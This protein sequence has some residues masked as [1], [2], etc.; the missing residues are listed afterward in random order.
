[1]TSRV[2][3]ITVI[4][5]QLIACTP[6]A[7]RTPDDTIVLVIE[8][9]MTT[10]DPR[11]AISSHD[12]K[13]T[14]LVGA[15]L[16]AVD[17]PDVEPRLDLASKVDMIDPLTFDFTIR[18]DAKFSDG[19]P[20]TAEDVAWTY[21]SVLDP[22]STSLHHKGFVE[23]YQS[24]V[25]RSPS[26]VRFSLK[27]PL[28]TLTSDLDFAI[29]SKGKRLGAGPYKLRELN[30]LHVLLDVNPHYYGPK[31]KTPHVEI[32]F[33]RDAS[34]RLLMLVGGS[35]DL[36]QNSIRLDLIDEVK[37]RPRIAIEAAPSVILTYLM[38]NNADPVLKDL[39]VRQAIALAIDRQAIVDAKFGGRAKLASGLL[40]AFH[41]AFAKE[42]PTWTRDLPRARQLLDEAGLRDPDGDGPRPR[43]SLVYKTSSDAFRVTLAR[44]IA[45]QLAEVGIDVEVRSF[46]F[47][48]FFA[49]VK[50]GSY[51]LASMQSAEL[52][53][54]DY[55]YFYFHSSRI[56]DAKNPDGGNRWRYRN[57]TL[58]RLTE[59]GRREM[60]REKRKLI[61]AEA[62][63]VVATDLPIVPLWHEDNVALTNR[64]MHGYTI[65]PNARYIGLIN[66]SKQ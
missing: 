41:W 49:D 35:A 65:T 61:Y 14:R 44:V 30:A 46:E 62:Q 32:K 2:H 43:L 16:T 27:Q 42:L 37:D 7:R 11:F 26:V 10:A 13:L 3:V 60:D 23:R 17:T 31:P 24:V 18:P 52:N 6:R 28:A 25:A 55:Y 4:L 54:P 59:E 63:K 9:A 12:V 19:T 51:Q 39:R 36:I 21:E 8:S 33:V 22:K 53:E 56:P 66:A 64:T 45:A 48:T 1:M 34:A 40:P 29:L 50:K 47:A 15:G 58:D 20:V 57:A 38:I 5:A